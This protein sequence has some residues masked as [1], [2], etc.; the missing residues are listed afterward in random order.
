MAGSRKSARRTGA[1]K[2]G[3]KR[4]ATKKRAVRKAATK[5]RT[6]AGRSKTTGTGKLK[7][8]AAKGLRAARG[9]INTVRKAGEKTWEVLK[10]TTTQ[11]V[12]GVRDKLGD[13]SDRNVT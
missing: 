9:G 7:R 11:V 10:S 1:K 2:R 12:E 3:A 4:A 13:E 5:R 8:K 6:R